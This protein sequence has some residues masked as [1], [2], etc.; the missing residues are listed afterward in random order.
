MVFRIKHM[1]SGTPHIPVWVG[2]FP[3]RQRGK[4]DQSSTCVVT[5]YLKWIGATLKQW[6][7]TLPNI[8]SGPIYR[9]VDGA[10]SAPQDGIVS[11]KFRTKPIEKSQWKCGLLVVLGFQIQWPWRF[12]QWANRTG[13]I[14]PSTLGT[15]CGSPL[16]CECHSHVESLICGFRTPDF[17]PR[18]FFGRYHL[19]S[20]T[21]YSA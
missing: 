9:Y 1:V 4:V 10:N 7:V 13:W 16:R 17:S 3:D 11:K 8:I 18:Q 15:S 20:S 14:P 21:S 6:G 2:I 19:Q 5:I 12:L